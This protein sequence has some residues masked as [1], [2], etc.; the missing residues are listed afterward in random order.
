MEAVL[1][2][3]LLPVCNSRAISS[4]AQIPA[5]THLGIEPTTKHFDDVDNQKKRDEVRVYSLIRYIKRGYYLYNF[6]ILML[7]FT[8]FS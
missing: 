1:S 5:F 4:C 2:A 8:I 3:R 6:I 7:I